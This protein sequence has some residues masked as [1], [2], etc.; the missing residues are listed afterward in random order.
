MLLLRNVNNDKKSAS[1]ELEKKYGVYKIYVSRKVT[2]KLNREGRCN[3]DIRNIVRNH[4]V[5]FQNMTSK[6]Y[7]GH[8]GTP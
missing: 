4:S 5:V 8:S 7:N 3:G 6:G 2:C 1:T